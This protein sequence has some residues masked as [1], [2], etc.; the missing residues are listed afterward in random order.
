MTVAIYFKGPHFRCLLKKSEMDF[1]TLRLKKKCA[2]IY[3][4][5]STEFQTH[6][7][8]Q[9][10]KFFKLNQISI[11][12]FYST[13]SP[14]VQ[15]A[16]MEFFAISTTAFTNLQ[17]ISKSDDKRLCCPI[18]LQLCEFFIIHWSAKSWNILGS[19]ISNI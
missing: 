7:W 1:N 17:F 13:K 2:R 19:K 9:K 12:H 10:S 16:L 6:T 11:K 15:W 5:F 8:T 3:R 4:C 14:T 18:Y